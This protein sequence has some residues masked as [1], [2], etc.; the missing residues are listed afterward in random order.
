MKLNIMMKTIIST[1]INNKF[2]VKVLNLRGKPAVSH[3]FFKDNKW[4]CQYNIGVINIS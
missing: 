3:Y 4:Y 2:S 1:I